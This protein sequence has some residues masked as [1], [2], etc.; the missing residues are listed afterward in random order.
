MSGTVALG[1]FGGIVGFIMDRNDTLAVLG[2]ALE[3]IASIA[4]GVL[5]GA[6]I[7]ALLGVFG[8]DRRSDHAHRTRDEP[9]GD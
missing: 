5:I 9:G 3:G 4:G 1:A 7:G 6:A 2:V 8:G